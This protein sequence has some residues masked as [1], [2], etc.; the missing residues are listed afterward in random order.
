MNLLF[1]GLVPIIDWLDAIP[2]KAQV[3]CVSATH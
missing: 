3:G 2:A 1:D